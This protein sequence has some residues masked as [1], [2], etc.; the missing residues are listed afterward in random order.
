MSEVRLLLLDDHILFREGLS[1]LLADEADFLIAAQCS[2]SE[3]AL[4]LLQAGVNPDLILLDFNLGEENGFHFLQRARERGFAGK[5]LMVAAG[6]SPADTLRA[7]D[8]GALGLF[9]KHAPPAEL[10]SAIRRV[11]R[12]ESLISPAALQALLDAAHQEQGRRSTALELS[13]RE[14]AVLRG[15]FAGLANK[16]IAAQLDMSEGYVKALLQQLFSK[17]GVRTRAQLVRIALEHHFETG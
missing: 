6:M 14:R 2:T 8:A 11:M 7:L 17:T 1:R 4:G 12:G 15:V 16:E 10:V 13:T 3:E 9:L 5:I